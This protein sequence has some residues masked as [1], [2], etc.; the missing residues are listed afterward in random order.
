MGVR[1]AE[2]LHVKMRCPGTGSPLHPKLL[3]KTMLEIKIFFCTNGSHGCDVC[4]SPKSKAEFT[5]SIWKNPMTAKQ[6]T[7]CLW[8]CRPPCTSQARPTFPVCRDPGC[9]EQNCKRDVVP[10]HASLL[11]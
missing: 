6:R 8:C 7:L 9:Q 10:L 1:Y 4:H 3:P 11:Y 2:I 5:A